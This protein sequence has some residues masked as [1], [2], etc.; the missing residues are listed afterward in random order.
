[1]S[2]KDIPDGFNLYPKDSSFNDALAPLY[3][4][5]TEEKPVVGLRV[6]K[7]HCNPMGIC[8]GGVYMSLMDFALNSAVCHAAGKYMGMPTISMTMDFL[9]SAREGDWI[10]TDVEPIKLTNTMGFAQG[11]I[12]N[13]AN[14]ILFRASGIYKLPKNIEQAPGVSV[15]D[16]L[17]MQNS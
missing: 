17:A 6:E 12:R 5:I 1:M 11:V 13:A 4:K 8:H 15:A 9:S 16:L 14:D 7:H 2:E 3:L 10:W